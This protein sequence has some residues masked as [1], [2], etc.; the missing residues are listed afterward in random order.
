LAGGGKALQD[1][2]ACALRAFAVACGLRTR[3][4]ALPAAAWA[5]T[6]RVRS[7][8]CVLPAH[9]ALPLTQ[10]DLGSNHFAATVRHLKQTKPK[11]HVECLTPDFCGQHDKIDIVA[12][13]GL[14]VYAHNLETGAHLGAVSPPPPLVP[15][16]P[17]PLCAGP[18]A[19]PFLAGSICLG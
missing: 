1:V 7:P 14:D 5:N 19:H 8:C 6:A 4:A 15:V 3:S 13:S 9:P 2:C 10:P 11:L 18:R 16:S 17:G 12:K